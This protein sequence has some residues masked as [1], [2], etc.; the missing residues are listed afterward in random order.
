VPLEVRTA[1]DLIGQS[2]GLQI[3]AKESQ[4]EV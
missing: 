2:L 4:A 3:G 1:C